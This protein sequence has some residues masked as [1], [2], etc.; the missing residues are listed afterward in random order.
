[1]SVFLLVFSS[2]WLWGWHFMQ[3]GV[4]WG[5]CEKPSYAEWPSILSSKKI[6]ERVNSN[7]SHAVLQIPYL[8]PH[9]ERRLHQH[10]IWPNANFNF[11][12]IVC[13]WRM[14]D[15]WIIWWG[16]YRSIE[17]L[18][19]L[20]NLGID[21][22]LDNMAITRINAASSSLGGNIQSMKNI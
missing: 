17:T 12:S 19:Y 10:N 5:F 1:M 4:T 2:L 20:L 6:I 13:C 7:S 8:D 21:H 16:G 11:V 22:L 18:S 3:T 14:S 9:I 15:L